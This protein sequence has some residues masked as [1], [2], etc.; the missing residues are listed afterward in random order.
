VSVGVGTVKGGA[1]VDGS[2]L[3]N[4]TLDGSGLGDGTLDGSGLGQTEGDGIGDG[5]GIAVDAGEGLGAGVSSSL[6]P[7]VIG[8]GDADGVAAAEAL[9]AA[10]APTGPPADDRAVVAGF[11]AVEAGPGWTARATEV[12]GDE[13]TGVCTAGATCGRSTAA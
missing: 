8:D 5:S 9:C 1:G 13:A 4:G 6:S 2:G 7:T 10:G 12:A 11:G 3:G